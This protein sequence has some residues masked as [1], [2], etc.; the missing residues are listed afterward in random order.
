MK[1]LAALLAAGLLILALAA[2]ATAV[3][4]NNPHANTW[5]IFCPAL[6]YGDSF[7]VTAKGTPGWPTDWS[8][9]VTPIHLVAG[10]WTGYDS[11]TPFPGPSV[12]YPPGLAAKVIGPCWLHLYGGTTDTFDLVGTNAYFVVPGTH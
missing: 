11:G 6:G 3:P 1:A 8:P 12:T 7:T 9:G 4:V 10:D 2:P 5:E